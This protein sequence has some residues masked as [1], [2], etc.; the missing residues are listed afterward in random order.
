[1]TRR[2]LLQLA[3]TAP[4]V[5]LAPRSA[6]GTQRSLDVRNAPSRVVLADDSLAPS[7]IQ[8]TRDWTGTR[9]RSRIANR[10]TAP[11]AIKEITLFDIRHSLPRDTPL[12]GEGFQM[13]SQTGGTLGNIIDLGNYTDL[14]HY[15]L[16]EPAGA[17]VVYNL[18]TLALSAGGGQQTEHQLL[19]F[20]SCARFSGRFHVRPESIEVVLDAEGMSLNPGATCDLEE[21]EFVSGPDREALLASIAARLCQHHRP[22]KFAAP[23]SGWCSWYC[24]GPNVTAKQVLDN[25]EVIARDIPGLRYIQIDDGYQPA[26]GDWLETGTAFGGEVQSVLRQIRR[27]GFEPAIWVAPFIAEEGSRL[28]KTHPEWFVKDA[29]GKPLRADRVTFGGWRRGP[30]YALDGTHPGAQSHLEQVFRTMRDDWGC[31]YFKLDANFWGAIHGGR[32]DDPAAT[33]IDAYRRGMAAVLRG[34]RDAFVLGCN[35]PLWPSIGVIHG[36]RSS[37][38]I[39]R[40]WKRV[41]DTARQNLSRNWQ[42]GRLWWNDPDAI[43]LT[44]NLTDDE[45]RFHASVIFATGGMILSGDDLTTITPARLAMLRKLQPP[46]A[47]AAR[48]ADVSLRVG[49]V[50]LPGRQ[51][52]C[53]FNWSEAPQHT[54]YSLPRSAHVRDFWTDEDLGRLAAGR[55]ALTLAPHSGRVLMC[56]PAS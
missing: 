18:L 40:D 3:A 20:T 16:S 28:F 23:P 53:L 47:T 49:V 17:R 56:T 32:F 46:S 11:V 7:T 37:H 50:D 14:K 45:F 26:M 41:A 1:M 6:D 33:R 10:G 44:G 2:E 42:N 9:C 30:W 15:K 4:I 48:F 25:L 52:V 55:H 29:D 21:F 12:Y 35:H 13:L 24:F 22:L 34:T 54:E 27:R 8:L 19:A 5:A 36:S 43:V 51:A 31:T 38:D 39:R